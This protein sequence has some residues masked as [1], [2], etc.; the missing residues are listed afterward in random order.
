MN[1]DIS[2]SF[3]DKLVFNVAILI[4]NW[5]RNTK[6]IVDSKVEII[7]SVIVFEWQKNILVTKNFLWWFT[8]NDPYFTFPVTPYNVFKQSW[9]NS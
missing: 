7:L 9:G 4:K 2:I 3:E 5:I 6:S 1:V 8:K